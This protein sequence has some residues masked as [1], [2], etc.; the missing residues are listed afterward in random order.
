ME[1]DCTRHVDWLP[2]AYGHRAG[3][4]PSANHGAQV[5][6]SHAP[7]SHRQQL[8]QRQYIEDVLPGQRVP[9]TEQKESRNK[10][11][12]N[13]GNTESTG[14]AKDVTT[15]TAS[16]TLFQYFGELVQREILDQDQFKELYPT[17]INV[18]EQALHRGK[19]VATEE[20]ADL[21]KVSTPNLALSLYQEVHAPLK[22]I[23]CFAEEKRF[24]ELVAY[25]IKLWDYK[26]WSHVLAPGY[27]FRAQITASA[28]AAASLSEDNFAQISKAFM[29]ADMTKEAHRVQQAGFGEH[30]ST[31]NSKNAPGNAMILDAM[32]H[33]RSILLLLIDDLEYYDASPLARVAVDYGLYEAA[34]ALYSKG[35]MNASALNILCTKIGNLDRARRFALTCKEPAV[36]SAF[37]RFYL[38]QRNLGGAIHAFRLAHDHREYREIIR[39]AREQEN[40]DGVVEYLNMVQ[41]TVHNSLVYN[42][43]EEAYFRT[44][45][46]V[47]DELQAILQQEVFLRTAPSDEIINQEPAQKWQAISGKGMFVTSHKGSQVSGVNLYSVKLADYDEDR[48]QIINQASDIFLDD[49]YMIVE[50]GSALSDPDLPHLDPHLSR[51]ALVRSDRA[52]FQMEDDH[53]SS[54]RARHLRPTAA[55]APPSPPPNRSRHFLPVASSSNGSALYFE[56]EREE[57]NGRQNLLADIRKGRK[58]KKVDNVAVK[59]ELIRSM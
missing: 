53:T 24:A 44:N 47:P 28:I 11:E 21:V 36:W 49:D 17:M 5:P 58:L 23:Q 22:A 56:H 31:N 8:D 13:N 50:A 34:F 54:G 42:Q 46:P 29:D 39:L 30:T 43:L 38:K 2:K 19:L 12:T 20:L 51:R 10:V 4:V 52:G 32:R 25:L 35:M 1:P 6:T 9:V 45:Q 27:R 41:L 33:R 40:W 14:R 15:Q 57:S 16:T 18:L 55:T 48:G 59:R 7:S 3:T 37:G 26:L